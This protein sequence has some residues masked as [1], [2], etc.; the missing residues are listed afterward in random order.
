VEV[1]TFYVFEKNKESVGK[2]FNYFFIQVTDEL[3]YE[4]RQLSHNGIGALRS[5]P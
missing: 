5:S 1:K 4:A 2:K 3:Q